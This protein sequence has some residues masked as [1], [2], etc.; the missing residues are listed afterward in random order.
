MGGRHRTQYPSAT[1]LAFILTI[2]VQWQAKA[3]YGKGT[4]HLRH[5]TKGLECFSWR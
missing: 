1:V 4:Y 2:E 5:K 3:P